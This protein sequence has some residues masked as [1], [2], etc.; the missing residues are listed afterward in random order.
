MSNP[1]EQ[2]ERLISRYL[3]D[4]ITPAQQR[5]LNAMLRRDPAAEELFEQSVALDREMRYALRRAAGRPIHRVRRLRGWERV[6][7]LGGVAAAACLALVLWLAP[8]RPADR[9]VTDDGTQ[10]AGSWFAPPPSPGDTFL[11]SAPL[12]GG[13]AADSPAAQREWIVIP[14]QRQG[15]FLIVEVKRVQPRRIRSQQEF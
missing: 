9:V 2:L 1:S 10:R 13:P 15:E 7:Q 14:G 11:P 8:Q 12:S 6:V 4:E 5:E 3:D